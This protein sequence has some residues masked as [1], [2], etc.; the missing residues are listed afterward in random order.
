MRANRHW[1]IFLFL[2]VLFSCSSNTLVKY[3][4][5]INNLNNQNIPS[6][7]SSYG[8]IVLKDI[9]TMEIQLKEKLQYSELHRLRI[10]KVLNTKGFNYA[11]VVIPYGSSNK[12]T[13]EDAFTITPD[14]SI[15]KVQK[16]E[17]YDISLYPEYVFYSDQRAKI[18]T[19]PG[20]SEGSILV[21]SYT[22]T[23]S[24]LTASAGWYFQETVPVLY[25]EFTLLYP[26]QLDIHYK[27]YG[28]LNS[29]QLVSSPPGFKSSIKWIEKNIPP[30]SIEPSMPPT[31]S[32]LKRVMFS[33]LGM[34]QWNDVSYWYAQLFYAQMKRFSVSKL[35][36][37]DTS[38]SKD[39]IG[40]DSL[41]RWIQKNIRYI[42][43]EI[44]VG[45]YKP[46][47]ADDVYR[48]K[49][50]DC[51]DMVVLACAI[52]KRIGMNIIP[53]L[54]PF[55]NYHQVDTALVSPFYFNHL[56]AMVPE[57]DD[58][59]FVDFTS[60]VLPTG[61]LPWYLQGQYG[62]VVKE[63]GNGQL[64]K[65]P[66][67]SYHENLIE[68]SARIYLEKDKALIRG[69]IDFSGNPA[70]DI[71]RLL[72]NM[73]RNEKMLI[74]K[75]LI[76]SRWDQLNIDTLHYISTR[77]RLAIRYTGSIPIIERDGEKYFIFN[78]GW[79]F[80]S[81][82]HRIFISKKRIHDI[83]LKYQFQNDIVREI[84]LNDHWIPIYNDFKLRK[85]SHFG[86]ILYNQQ[87]KRS[88]M[89][90]NIQLINK[91]L[92]IRKEEYRD[93][94]KFLTNLDSIEKNYMIFKKKTH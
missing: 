80:H 78:P 62:L 41:Y 81:K 18:F 45:G 5:E 90:V 29:P 15:L 33:P 10:I 77:K 88:T 9:G 52:G 19:F 84:F 89:K 79:S 4:P 91:R 64:V 69:A 38:K 54:V 92:K 16:N 34:E 30:L 71:M 40:L 32:I 65:L 50:G 8:A 63:D 72:Y 70:Y 68:D 60:K 94:K 20:V 73:K 13:I 87:I 26:S 35:S 83:L 28:D 59:I 31:K 82:L 7:Y 46:H 74:L 6:E 21:Y 12:V 49:Y 85:K 43:V 55:R 44:G 3:L 22:M 25:S 48:K 27:E 56:I 53:V 14:G 75:N 1:W 42:A 86:E 24:Y 2:F 66:S 61:K 76:Y 93:F 11:N 67:M 47:P 37:L 36:F 57:N 17:I 58:T 39:K 23:Y 51:K